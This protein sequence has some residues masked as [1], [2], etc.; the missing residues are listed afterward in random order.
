MN[1]HKIKIIRNILN[2]F[3]NE[4]KKYLK[5]HKIRHTLIKYK[6]SK[7]GGKCNIFDA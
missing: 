5:D 4:K 7:K 3:Y 6:S 1:D 2:D